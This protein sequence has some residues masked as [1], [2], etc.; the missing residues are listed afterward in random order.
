MIYNWL[1]FVLTCSSHDG[2]V[3]WPFTNQPGMRRR[4]SASKFSSCECLSL[5]LFS[6]FCWP[7]EA[8]PAMHCATDESG[9]TVQASIVGWIESR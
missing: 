2:V 5:F 8:K 1:V 6:P 9:D 7:L 3:H 4:S